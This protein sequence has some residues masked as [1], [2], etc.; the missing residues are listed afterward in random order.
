MDLDDEFDLPRIQHALVSLLEQF[1]MLRTVVIPYNLFLQIVLR[2]VNSDSTVFE[3]ATDSLDEYT[4]HLKNRG[5]LSDLHFGDVIT[6]I[7]IE[8]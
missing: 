2:H 3:T 4:L 6:K 7:F 8:S 5:L 1:D